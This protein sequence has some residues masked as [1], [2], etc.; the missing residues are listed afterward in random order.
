MVLGETKYAQK[1][2]ICT[3]NTFKVKKFW[4]GKTIFVMQPNKQQ[5]WGSNEKDSLKSCY[6]KHFYDS[7][8]MD[9][10]GMVTKKTLLK[11]I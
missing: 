1:C 11:S 8:H 3:Q 10:Q 9:V 6:T 5:L 4:F 2:Y 7:K